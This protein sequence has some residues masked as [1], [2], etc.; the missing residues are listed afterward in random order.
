MRAP[1]SFSSPPDSAQTPAGSFRWHQRGS[2]GGE[3]GAAHTGEIRAGWRR[4]GQCPAVGGPAPFGARFP[5]PLNFP[6]HAGLLCL[7]AL[8]LPDSPGS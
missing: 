5:W 2:E 4:R 6:T 7:K 3:V 8:L 1:D